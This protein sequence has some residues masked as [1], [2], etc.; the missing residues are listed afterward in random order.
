MTVKS[1]AKSSWEQ[2]NSQIINP[3]KTQIQTIASSL[4]SKVNK[5]GDTV[6]GAMTSSVPNVLKRDTND[7]NLTI[8]GGT[9]WQSSAYLNLRGSENPESYNAGMFTLSACD[10]NGTLKALDGRTNGVLSW[11]GYRISINGKDSDNR[12]IFASSDNAGKL[13]LYGGSEYDGGAG[14]YLNGKAIGTSSAGNISLHAKTDTQTNVIDIYPDG[15]VEVNGYGAIVPRQ[16]NNPITS[17]ANDTPANWRALGSGIWGYTQANCLNGQ[18]NQYGML[19]S[20]VMNGELQ[21]IWLNLP[22]GVRY[23]RGANLS[24]W[25]QTSGNFVSG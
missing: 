18:P 12:C 7:S 19:I 22:N 16:G 5:S 23:H 11:G 14:I 15:R 13:V 3:L 6:S 2:L 20:I 25:S 9:S 21:Q 10:T 1:L 17:K 8:Y 24:G 4:T